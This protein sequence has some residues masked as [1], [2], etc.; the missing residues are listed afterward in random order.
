[1][2][3]PDPTTPQVQ[4]SSS[5]IAYNCCLL[6]AYSH[7][8]NIVTHAHEE[9]FPKMKLST[10]STRRTQPRRLP[11]TQRQRPPSVPLLVGRWNP[12]HTTCSCAMF[13]ISLLLSTSLPRSTSATPFGSPLDSANLYQGI[14]DSSP[15][16]RAMVGRE[17]KS[18]PFSVAAPGAEPLRLSHGTTT[19]AVVCEG[20]VIAAVD[21]RASMGSFVGSRTTQKVTRMSVCSY[22]ASGSSTPCVQSECS[23]VKT[24]RQL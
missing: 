18:D 7:A 19:V 15:L 8:Y 5:K 14:A 2:Y 10:T 23:L 1:M 3:V 13:I 17:Q 11:P 16:A 22:Q 24:V 20:G 4:S 21:S 12:V 6:L 9:S